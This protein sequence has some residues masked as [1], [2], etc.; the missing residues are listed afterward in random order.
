[1]TEQV[2]LRAQGTQHETTSAIDIYVSRAG[3]ACLF[4]VACG[5]CA[6]H[7][8]TFERTVETCVYLRALVHGFLESVLKYGK[9]SQ[10]I[11]LKPHVPKC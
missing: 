10:H 1:M 3:A 5:R 2:S 4:A 8:P 9:G 11:L 7:V 6:L